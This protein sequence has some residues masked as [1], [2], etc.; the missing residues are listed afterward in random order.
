MAA[1]KYTFSISADFPNQKVDSDSLTSEV[2]ADGGITTALDCINTSGDDCD[3]WFVDAL[4]A[5]EVTALNAVVAAHQGDPIPWVDYAYVDFN[6][7]KT[8]TS[9]EYLLCLE[10]SKD[11]VLDGNY[12]VD[13]TFSWYSSNSVAKLQ[14]KVVL[15]DTTTVMEESTKPRDVGVDNTERISGFGEYV[16]TAGTHNA[17]LYFATGKVNREVGIFNAALSFR[18]VS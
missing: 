17:K 1:T 9:T 2:N 8:T 11:Y 10:L 4:A 3:I 5:P 15:D 7:T 6:E 16:L 12:L 18:R 13:Y 14:C